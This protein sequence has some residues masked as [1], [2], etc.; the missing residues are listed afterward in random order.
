M[1]LHRDGFA[2]DG[3]FG[4]SDLSSDQL[5]P[6]SRKGRASQIAKRKRERT[7]RETVT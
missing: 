3:L 7:R 6:D 2:R 5:G 4:D 1:V